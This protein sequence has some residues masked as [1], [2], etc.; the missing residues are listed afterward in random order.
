MDIL[1]EDIYGYGFSIVSTSYADNFV[2]NDGENTFF[3]ILQND[4]IDG[5]KNNDTLIPDRSFG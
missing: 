1:F 5:G 2:G 4:Y 3:G